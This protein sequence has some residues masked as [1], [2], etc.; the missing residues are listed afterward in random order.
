MLFLLVALTGAAACNKQPPF[1]M[2]DGKPIE[3]AQFDA[4]LKLKRIP[5]Q[6]GEQLERVLDE[7]LKREALAAAVERAGKLDKQLID[8]ELNEFRKEMLISRYFE[9][10]LDEKVTD[11]AVRNFYETNAANY[12]DK[13]IH[14]AHILVRTNPKLSDEE[15]K[16]KLTAAQEAYSQIKAGTD[17][18]EVAA[19][20]SEDQGS[21]KKGGDIGWVKEGTIDPLFSKKIF[22]MNV[23][24]VS[25]P[26]ETPFGFHVVKVL[27]AAQTVRRP[28]DAVSGDIRHRLRAEAKDAEVD[29]LR[30]QSQ[31]E[32]QGKP[33]RGGA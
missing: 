29:R 25:E 12:E 20:H 30:Q 22:S 14:V 4:Y 7:Y 11:Q 26:F 24:D 8:A 32:R 3:K 15:R 2:V 5:N 19:T 21:A 16:A 1:A 6:K 17:F 18:A 33:L 28:F 10:Y 23:G 9:K 31:I 13:K 27:E